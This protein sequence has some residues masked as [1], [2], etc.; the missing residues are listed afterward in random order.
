MESFS[1]ALSSGRGFN[2]KL[3]IQIGVNTFFRVCYH[4]QSQLSW[5]TCSHFCQN[6]IQ[7]QLMSTEVVMVLTANVNTNNAV[8]YTSQLFYSS[9]TA[10]LIHIVFF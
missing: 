8:C 9:A 4:T 1:M 3:D 5:S 10:A 6:S 7:Q 2:W